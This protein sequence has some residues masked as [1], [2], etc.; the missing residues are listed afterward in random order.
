MSGYADE[1]ALAGIAEF[2]PI[3]F[4]WRVSKAFE[5][6]QRFC[7]L[8]RVV[9]RVNDGIAP[10]VVHDQAGSELVVT[11]AAATAPVHRLADAVDDLLQARDDVGVAVLAQLHHDPAAAHLVGD[12]AGGAGAG[13]GI[14]N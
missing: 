4:R 13:E 8:N 9:V 10:T 5:L 11:K 2:P 1:I 3:D 7:K 12:C 6:A 14:E